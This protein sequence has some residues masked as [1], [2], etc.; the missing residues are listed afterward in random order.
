[1][2]RVRI[3]TRWAAAVSCV[4]H[5]VNVA[6]HVACEWLRDVVASFVG[7]CVA[8]CLFVMLLVVVVLLTSCVAECTHNDQQLHAA[9]MDVYVYGHLMSMHEFVDRHM[10]M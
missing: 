9:R 7:S 3:K 10:Y 8:S 2:K 5:H 4:I 6:S 1:M